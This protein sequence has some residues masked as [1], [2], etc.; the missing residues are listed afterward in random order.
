MRLR[1]PALLAALALFCAHVGANEPAA[2]TFEAP[3]PAD[4][5]YTNLG[6]LNVIPVPT[7][8]L[9]GARITTFG[10]D[11]TVKLSGGKTLDFQVETSK[12]LQITGL[13]VNKL[14][15]LIASGDYPNEMSAEHQEFINDM[16]HGLQTIVT[17]ERPCRLVSSD[18]K[19]SAYIYHA[20]D[21][22]KETWLLHMVTE[23]MTDSYTGLVARDFNKQEFERLILQEAFLK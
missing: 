20:D 2:C 23:G 9:S 21:H 10:K 11:L 6:S 1:H 22:G 15:G 19:R 5:D 14:P 13:Q 16:R 4:T 3:R 8:A 12:T 18:G 17:G 7:V